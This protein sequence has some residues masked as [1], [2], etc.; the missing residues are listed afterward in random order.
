[1]KPTVT[2]IGTCPSGFGKRINFLKEKNNTLTLWNVT[3]LA[4]KTIV[5]S[6]MMMV[7]GYNY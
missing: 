6:S 4:F 7:I 5:S 3:Y 2:E 1:M